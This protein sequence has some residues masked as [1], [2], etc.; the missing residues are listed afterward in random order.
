M[1]KNA[2]KSVF[3]AI[4]FLLLSNTCVVTSPSYS[5]RIHAPLIYG[6]SRQVVRRIPVVIFVDRLLSQELPKMRER[7][8]FSEGD[9]LGVCLHSHSSAHN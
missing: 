3:Y 2:K 8:A 7:R 1:A 9:G 4:Y 5:P 6:P